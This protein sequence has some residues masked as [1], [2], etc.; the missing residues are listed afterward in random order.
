MINSY[1]ISKSMSQPINNFRREQRWAQTKPS[2][3]HSVA[4]G[5]SIDCVSGRLRPRKTLTGSIPVL[6]RILWRRD[7]D[8]Q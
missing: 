4:Q 8:I 3:G 1:V 5:S 2:G 7:R 6:L